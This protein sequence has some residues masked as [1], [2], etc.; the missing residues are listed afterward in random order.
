M[1]EEGTLG[2]AR[3]QEEIGEDLSKEQLQ[4]KLNQARDSIS[5]T[6]TEIKETVANQVQ[7]VKDT[8]DWREQFRRRPVAWSAG[9]LGAGFLVGYGVAAAI[10]GEGRE[11]TVDYYSGR[12]KSY[13]AQ[14]LPASRT[15]Q[16][17]SMPE[18]YEDEG[19]GLLKKIT[20]SNAYGRVRQEVGEI[21]DSFVKE[22]SN[23]AKQVVMPALIN[24]L[25]N[26]I[27]GYLPSTTQR[28]TTNQD[29]SKRGGA[30]YEPRLERT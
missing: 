7:A 28:S 18:T 2:L 29:T 21:G 3:A 9:A 22:L 24:S 15:V 14:P 27:G 30:T 26:F 8:L 25:R 10:K 6:V 13:A 17:Q 20:T 11:E 12:S 23:T 1:A 16:S 19:P 5:N 4:R